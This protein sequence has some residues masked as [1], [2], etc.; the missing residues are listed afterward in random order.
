MS[1][2][3]ISQEC[4][5]LFTLTFEILGSPV[6]DRRKQEIRNFS[7]HD[8]RRSTPI[9]GGVQS[10]ELRGVV[11]EN[12]PHFSQFGIDIARILQ[13]LQHDIPQSLPKPLA[14]P[15]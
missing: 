5:V 1:H 4:G 13:R 6:T 8:L 7:M 14:E 12:G 10:G 11:C 2:V 15:M 3:A 9:G